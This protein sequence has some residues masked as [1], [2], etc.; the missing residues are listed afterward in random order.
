[1]SKADTVVKTYEFN[2]PGMDEP[3]EGR[4]VFT[5]QPEHLPYQW[6]VSH[7]YQPSSPNAQ[8][9]YRP[10]RTR[11]ESAEAAEVELNK[12]VSEFNRAAFVK[13]RIGNQAALNP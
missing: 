6:I 1:M 11:A 10:S 3:V 2:V 9:I 12:Y 13:N 7:F 5:G 8:G 4:V